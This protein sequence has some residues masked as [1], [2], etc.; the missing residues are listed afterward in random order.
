MSL[1]E[2]SSSI[3]I[4]EQTAS[5]PAKRNTYNLG[6]KVQ[7]EAQVDREFMDFDNHMLKFKVNFV[8]SSV[9]ANTNSWFASQCIRNLRVKTLG[10]Q[11]I[12]NEIREYRAY[13]QMVKELTS[14]SDFNDSYGSV[15]EG[16][17]ATAIASDDETLQYGHKF[18]THIF[19]VAEYY[20][21]HFH[22]GL[23]IEFDLPQTIHE[24]CYGTVLPTSITF[25]D[26]ELLCDLKQLKPEIENELVS[27]MSEQ[28]LFIDYPEI[29]SQENDMKA[30]SGNQSYDIVG[31][32]GRVQAVHT[33]TIT[34]TSRDDN[35]EE[36]FGTWG[37][38]N[39]SGYRFKL[40]SNYLNY[41]SIE[42]ATNTR[43]EQTYELLKSLDLYTKD[44]M[45]TRCGDS[46]LTPALL[47]TNRFAVG[48]K[49]AKAQKDID[50]TISSSIDKDRNNM[51][52]ELD[53]SSSPGVGTIY[54]HIKVDK[55][56]QLLPGS[57]VRSVR[58]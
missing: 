39:L 25:T 42:V 54:T 36:Y 6:Q 24:L 47:N 17:N 23:L 53:F 56:L 49:V 12:G 50:M 27:L 20:P 1:L 38:N 7:I 5:F 33:Y 3:E 44:R 13:T 45:E 55:R 32:D 4:S 30:Q 8:G 15:M 16:A 22:Q 10:G 51:R 35:T 11:Q 9:S 21:A 26:F 14:N 31:I 52:V 28:K 34:D 57:V 2:K 40:G 43:A 58:N 19:A 48:R 41:E 37:R 18:I 29:V 46:A